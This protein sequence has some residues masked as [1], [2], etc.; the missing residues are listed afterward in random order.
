MIIYVITVST[1]A[2]IID[3]T[4]VAIALFALINSRSTPYF[5]SAYEKI[6][7][8]HIKNTIIQKTIAY[9][10]LYII[11]TLPS[12]FLHY[13][14]LLQYALRCFLLFQIAVKHQ[15]LPIIPSAPLIFQYLYPV[16]LP[17]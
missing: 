11:I 7:D 14:F 1:M 15:A 2:I 16:P 9:T 17:L 6:T 3:I 12:I 5:L 8:I 13:W 4:Y 10:I